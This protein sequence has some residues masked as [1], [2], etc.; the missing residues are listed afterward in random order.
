[1]KLNHQKGVFMSIVD[2]FVAKNIRAYP[3]LFSCRTS[4][5]HQTL[6][7]IGNGLAWN[8]NGTI[9]CDYEEDRNIFYDEEQHATNISDRLKKI[10]VENLDEMSDFIKKSEN[11]E[12]INVK[13]HNL[14]MQF[15][16]DNAELLAQE[17]WEKTSEKYLL[18]EN[19]PKDA[20]NIYPLSEQH[21]MLCTVPDNIHP[22]WLDAVFEMIFMVF[23][24]SEDIFI[25]N[26]TLKKLGK[27]FGYPKN[28][29]KSYREF[30]NQK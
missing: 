28:K 3:T 10:F 29:P 19:Y 15:R 21:S 11:R 20:E 18:K 6:C 5:L 12:R 23:T 2:D 1:M 8:N 14:L 27:K 13:Y 17:T 9:E 26:R 30:S 16:R 25:A 22:D 24:F 7:V 4:V